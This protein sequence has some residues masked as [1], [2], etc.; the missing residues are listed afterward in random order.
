MNIFYVKQVREDLEPHRQADA[1]LEKF[2][3]FDRTRI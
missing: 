2:Y 1:D 3:G